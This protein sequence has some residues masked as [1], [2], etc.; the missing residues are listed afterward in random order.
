RRPERMSARRLLILPEADPADALRAAIDAGDDVACAL[1]PSGA[2]AAAL[3]ALAHPAD[4]ALLL[5]DDADAARA[6]G[7]DGVHLTLVPDGAVASARKK[8]G[9]D[10]IVGAFCGLSRHMAMTAAEAGADYIAFGPF[11]DPAVAAVAADHIA[12]WAETMEPPCV[13]WGVAPDDDDPHGAD[14]VACAPE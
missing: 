7:F 13:A 6:G 3:I 2:D 14:F 8:L 4:V 10:A 11:D 9:A 5:A 12:W 1:V